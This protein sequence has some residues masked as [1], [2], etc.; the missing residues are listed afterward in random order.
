MTQGFKTGDIYFPPVQTA[1][2]TLASSTSK[3]GMVTIDLLNA[4]AARGPA[5]LHVASAFEDGTQ[6]INAEK[7]A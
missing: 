4:M 3:Y 2:E 7:T 5:F 6:R 1:L